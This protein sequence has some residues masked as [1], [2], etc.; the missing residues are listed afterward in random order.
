MQT[1]PLSACLASSCGRLLLNSDSN[2]MLNALPG[3]L[4][5]PVVVCFQFLFNLNAPLHALP[6][7]AIQFLFNIH[8]N[9][10][11]FHCRIK[12]IIDWMLDWMVDCLIHYWLFGASI[13]IHRI[14]ADPKLPRNYLLYIYIY[15]RI[16]IAKLEAVRGAFRIKLDTNW[17]ANDRRRWQC[18]HRNLNKNW[19]A[20]DHRRR[21]CRQRNNL[22]QHQIVE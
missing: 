5:P 14:S 11:F 12:W 19:I 15:I 10:W 16:F 18:R 13:P 7:P 6:P 9:A 1:A 4:P 8:F 2:L 20:N 22:H 21:Q 17:I 3:A